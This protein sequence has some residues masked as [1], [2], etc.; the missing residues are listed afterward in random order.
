MDDR[1]DMD[2][3]MARLDAGMAASART[4]SIV[5]LRWRERRGG[6]AHIPMQDKLDIEELIAVLEASIGGIP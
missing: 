1:F 4:V 6:A 5:R 3:I 2:D